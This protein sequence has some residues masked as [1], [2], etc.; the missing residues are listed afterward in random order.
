M[1]LG[2]SGGAN[3]SSGAQQKKITGEL[4]DKCLLSPDEGTRG[5]G[6]GATEGSET[7]IS[8]LLLFKT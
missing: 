8:N 6:S 4:G 1:V 2:G 5:G 7:R 3:T